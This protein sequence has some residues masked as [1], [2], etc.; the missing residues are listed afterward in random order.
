MRPRVSHLEFLK[1]HH[2]V[3]IALDTFPFNGC[4]TTAHALWMGVPV[5]TLAGT[6][7]AARVGCSMLTNVGLRQLVA[8]DDAE[9][10]SIAV[11]LARDLT[12]LERL[13]ATLRERMEAAPNMDGAR[14]T[15]FLENAYRSIW[16]DYSRTVSEAKAP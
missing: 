14:F 10:V 3:D 4:T 6:V 16:A 11:A 7:H 9:Y 5:I 2:S 15:R 8:A 1:A 13:R 12:Q